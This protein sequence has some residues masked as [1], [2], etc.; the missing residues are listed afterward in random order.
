MGGPAGVC[1]S[2]QCARAGLRS[3]CGLGRS[4][5]LSSAACYQHPEVCH[6]VLLQE[7]EALVLTPPAVHMMLVDCVPN[8]VIS[9]HFPPTDNTLPK[10]SASAEDVS[11]HHFQLLFPGG[12]PV[13]VG[14]GNSC[15]DLQSI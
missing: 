9:Y 5:L 14:L 4:S 1:G 8:P 6:P 2:L 3:D 7:G 13:W 11:F 12:A 10:L 15:H